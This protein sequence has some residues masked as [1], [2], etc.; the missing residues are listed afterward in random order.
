MKML[1]FAAI[2]IALL[3]GS[4]VLA[5]GDAGN[6][7]LDQLKNPIDG[8]EL[9]GDLRYRKVYGE[10]WTVGDN[11]K[12]YGADKLEYDRIRARLGAKIG[13]GEGVNAHVRLTQEF[14]AYSQ[15]KENS[16]DYDEIIIDQLNVS[17]DNFLDM[18]VK[19][20]LGRQDIFMNKWL[21]FDGTPGDGSRTFFFD[22][23]RF[24]LDLDAG[25]TLDLVYVQNNNKA[26]S[27]LTFSTQNSNW[28][29]ENDEKAAILYYTDKSNADRA[30]EA[31]FIYKD[32]SVSSSPW[33]EDAEIYTYGGAL[34][35]S[36]NESLSYRTEAAMQFGE[37]GGEALQAFG[38]LNN[39]TYSFNDDMANALTLEYEYASG[40][41]PDTNMREDFDPLWGEWPRFSELYVYT[42]MAEGQPIADI[43]NLHRIGLTHTCNPMAKVSVRSAYHLLWTAQNQDTGSG[44]SNLRGQLFTNQIAYKINKNLSTRLNA[45]YF[46]PGDYL[47]DREDAVFLRAEVVVSF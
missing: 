24:I 20:T 40:D 36:I 10:D 1:L 43:T 8:V 21:I 9:Y 15:G 35:G 30:V 47:A 6:S 44:S 46:R 37:Q 25:K 39:L 3:L 11:A 13:L 31:Y 17:I 22:A 33:S 26:S 5:D 34:S 12:P 42:I 16:V 41:D 38:S 2:F 45:E 7:L 32:D 19:A 14:K 29:T 28:L 4:R 27:Q 23:A 18:P